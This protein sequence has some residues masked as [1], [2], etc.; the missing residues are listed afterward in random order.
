MKTE[1][2]D[3]WKNWLTTNLANGQDKNGL[4]KI[5]LDEG[6]SYT[7]I[8]FE[9]QFEPTVP[10]DQLV[11]PF[12]QHKVAAEPK[13]SALTDKGA[14]S[15]FGAAINP[16]SIFIPNGTLQH[17][18]RLALVSVSDFLSPHECVHIIEAITS[19]LRPSELAS[20]EPDQSFRTSRTCDLGRLQDSL[21]KDIDRRI[22]NLIGIDESY[23]ESIQGQY[24]TAGQEFKA[25]TDYF[26]EH[27]METHGQTMGQRTY[28]F[29]IYL[30]T[31]AKG[32]ETNFTKID[33]ALE[34]QQGTA[35]IWSSLNPDGSPNPNSMH[36]AQPVL[37]GHKA[38]ITKWFRSKSRLDPQPRMLTKSLN[39]FIPNYTTVGFERAKLST[40]LFAEIKHFYTSRSSSQIDENVP[41]D[42]IGNSIQGNN[43]SSSLIDLSEELRLKIHDELKRSMEDWCKK[44]L[45]PTYVYGIR[46]YHRGA[47]L[48]CHQD[49]LDTHIISAI[50]NVDQA[51]DEDWPLVIYDNYM[52][53]HEVML[54]PGE[55]IFYEGGRLSHGRP[56]P[57]NGDSYANIFCHFKPTDY[58]PPISN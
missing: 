16:E 9:M 35:V 12:H 4:F 21:I 37:D 19:Q 54:Q 26:E 5:L 51:V 45:K 55:I 50:I 1:F 56:K 8:K 39:D 58:M 29:M 10:L 38:V 20:Y 2:N 48:Q 24:Y 36:H 41:G 23:S 14:G 57:L 25:H 53:K 42:F 40:A 44:E 52:R 30:N 3:D 6:Y 15:N 46:I 13:Q 18:E 34:P 43:K 28:T 32:G 7:A 11:N 17:S 33:R 27:E 31:V 47:V 22:C 49:R